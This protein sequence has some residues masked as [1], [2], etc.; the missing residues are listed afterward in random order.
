MSRTT[1]DL[2]LRANPRMTRVFRDLPVYDVAGWTVTESDG[3]VAANDGESALVI[4][5]SGGPARFFLD[6]GS[7]EHDAVELVAG[8]LS[9]IE[10]QGLIPP[11]VVGAVLKLHGQRVAAARRVVA[12]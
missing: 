1:I 2:H 4:L 3:G 12:A 6:R 5:D 11:E 10:L 7:D 9:T 8:E